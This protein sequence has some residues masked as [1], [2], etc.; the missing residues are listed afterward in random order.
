MRGGR[1]ANGK[2]L[3]VNTDD[4]NSFLGSE[5]IH[6]LVAYLSPFLNSSR[7]FMLSVVPISTFTL[8]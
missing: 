3:G 2:P 7:R 8:R 1:I 5:N 4:R 6:I